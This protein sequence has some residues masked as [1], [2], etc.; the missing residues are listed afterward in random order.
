MRKIFLQSV[1]ALSAITA[2]MSCSKDIEAF[3][4]VNASW[5]PVVSLPSILKF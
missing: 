1:I 3:N 4:A 2:F 5:L